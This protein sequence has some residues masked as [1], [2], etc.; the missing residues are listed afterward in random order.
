MKLITDEIVI[1]MYLEERLSVVQISEKLNISFYKVRYILEKNKTPKRSISDA[2]TSLNITKYGK[3]PFDLKTDLSIVEKDL[4]ITGI[5][6]YWGEGAKTGGSIKL[7]NSDPEM[8][9]VFLMFLRKICRVDEGRIKM[10][11]HMYPDHKKDLL[12]SFWSSVTRI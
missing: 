1:K 11:V 10:L 9:K 4:K 8:I 5:M 3:Q 7:A 6:L 12:L 2:I